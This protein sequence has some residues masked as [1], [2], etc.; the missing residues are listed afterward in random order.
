MIS[1]GT[2]VNRSYTLYLPFKN[3]YIEVTIFF[4]KTSTYLAFKTD[5][6]ISML[7]RNNELISNIYR[8]LKT[9]DFANTFLDIR[10]FSSKNLDIKNQFSNI[11]NP[12]KEKVQY[13]CNESIKLSKIKTSNGMFD[14]LLYIYV[15]NFIDYSQNFL[16]FLAERQYIDCIIDRKIVRTCSLQLATP[17]CLEDIT[18]LVKYYQNDSKIIRSDNSIKIN[19]GDISEGLDNL[20]V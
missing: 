6:Q 8:D 20:D 3:T 19:S 18:K 2:K 12:Y 1:F 17:D 5:K 10:D 4:N 15:F 16:Y 13:V 9:S 7:C 11:L 14:S